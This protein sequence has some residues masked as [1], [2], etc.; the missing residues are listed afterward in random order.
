MIPAGRQRLLALGGLAVV[1]A[2]AFVL[3]RPTPDPAVP[4]PASSNPV[5]AGSSTRAE[6]PV[7]DV[8]LE[9]LTGEPNELGET[10]RN[11]FRF[12]PRPAPP[13][14]PRAAVVAPPPRG[15]VAPP[16]PTG[17]PPPP[18]IAL[19]F[20]GLVDAPTQ[21]GR[22]A[23][24]SDGRGGVFYGKEGD[25]IEGRYRVIRVGADSAELAYLDGRGRQTIRLSGQ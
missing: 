14:P 23:W 2:G 9:M 21:A 4:P 22:V 20:M 8:R 12:R 15:P 10:A 24:F 16:V 7:A 19:K 25:I 13:P 18:P 1:V 17:P 3:T 5:A 6:V 11:P